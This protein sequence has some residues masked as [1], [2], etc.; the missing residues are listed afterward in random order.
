[1]SD[2]TRVNTK[3]KWGVTGK[4]E[5]KEVCQLRKNDIFIFMAV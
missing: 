2:L 4:V 1:M 3:L 5:A